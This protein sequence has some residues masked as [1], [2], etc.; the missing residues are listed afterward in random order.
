MAKGDLQRVIDRQKVRTSSSSITVGS[1]GGSVDLSPYLLLDGSRA[2]TGNFSM[3]TFSIINVGLVDG[4]DISAHVTDVDA[5]HAKLH[6]LDDT[7]N[8]SGTLAWAK[9]NK[10]GS[11]ITDIVTRAHNNLQGIGPDDH[12]AR[13]HNITS[14]SDHTITA[15]TFGLVGAIASNLLGILTP[16]HTPGVNAKILRTNTD[17]SLTIDK[18]V[19]TAYVK[20]SAYMQAVTYIDAPILQY[21]GSI[22]INPTLDLT[23]NPGS[24]SVILASGKTFKSSGADSG[25]TGNGFIITS[26]LGEFQ[27]LT[28]RG[29][30]RVYELLIQRIRMTNG[31]LLVSSTGKVKTVSGP[32]S[33]IYTIVTE[34]EH[35]FLENDVI[36]A[37]VF[38]GSNIYR[39]DLT[40]VAVANTKQFTATLRAA[41]TAPA[42]GF[43]YGRLGNTTNASRQGVIYITS[44]DTYAPYLDVVNGIASHALFNTNGT[45]KVRLGRLDGITTG[46]GEYGLFATGGSNAGSEQSNSYVKISN[47]SILLNNVPLEF[48]YSGQ[49]TGYWSAD[50]RSFW[51]GP[52]ET[53]KRLSW[54][55]TT[56]TLNIVGNITIT[57]GNAATSASVTAAQTAAQTYTD[58]NAA[59]K[60]LGNTTVNWAGS[61]TRGGSAN[62]TLNVNGVSAATVQNGAGRASTGLNSSGYV[63]LPL[64]S[65]NIADTSG[66]VGLNMNANRFGYYDGTNW[67]VWL[68]NTGQFYFGGST[69]AHLE[70]N[71]TELL[72]TN[73]ST[74]QWYA[75]SANGAFYAGQGV[76]KLSQSGIEIYRGTIETTS[77][78]PE[79]GF[80]TTPNTLPNAQNS[81]DFWDTGSYWI[82]NYPNEVVN[83]SYPGNNI[84]RIYASSQHIVPTYEEFGAWQHYLD[85]V[86]ELPSYS[87]GY[88]GY[89]GYWVQRL[90][91]KAPHTYVT[92][93]MTVQG[94]DIVNTGYTIWTQTFRTTGAAAQII[95]GS[96][97]GNLDWIGYNTSSI[98]RLYTNGADR[99]TL[100]QEG[101]T[102]Q[103]GNMTATQF[104]QGNE[105]RNTGGGYRSDSWHIFTRTNG[106]PQVISADSLYIAT[107]GGSINA[108]AGDLYMQRGGSNRVALF[109]WGVQVY[110]NL[111]TEG[112]FSLSTVYTS[113]NKPVAPTVGMKMY[114]YNDGSKISLAVRFAGTADHK[115]LANNL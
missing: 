81:I 7:A 111:T 36:R 20:S 102:W 26:S 14:L 56:N 40:V 46:V 89:S 90:W 29:T 27:D 32:A 64:R 101:N 37:Q 41:S 100:S 85:G 77:G 74:V 3:G 57:G 62:D 51:I 63:A 78:T 79:P 2:M 108:G 39:S 113:A 11:N 76:V 21:T 68:A 48:R 67:K 13:S 31:S 42:V 66:V 91:L 61:N 87:T 65:S 58:N 33:G 82:H 114:N 59:T 88:A 55:G 43:E 52:T 110:S 47:E 60:N 103:L 104:V 49:R 5:H 18:L 8:H 19:G 99:W 22:S 84:F 107:N 96:R 24:N 83:F 38:T 1:G 105:I 94:G 115:L 98:F 25:F 17:G 23:F 15:S 45:V 109:S 50:G 80:G 4:V 35:G 9:V 54:D 72:G 92:G 106:T 28:V 95:F 86:I 97:N 75:S 112:A 70:W 30:M 71:G 73:G 44:D 16:E 93:A 69:G 53:D 34:E 6:D 12:H 10:T